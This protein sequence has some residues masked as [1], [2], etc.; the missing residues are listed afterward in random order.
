MN[1]WKQ[2]PLSSISEWPNIGVGM[3][4]LLV[5]LWGVLIGVLS[6]NYLYVDPGHFSGI[7]FTVTIVV[8]LIVLF[9]NGF[10]LGPIWPKGMVMVLLWLAF[11]FGSLLSALVNQDN[12]VGE[13]WQMWGVPIVYFFAFPRLACRKGCL[14]LAWS[15]VLGAIPYIIVSLANYPLITSYYK[16]V[17]T[18]P[19]AMGAMSAVF[20]AGGFSLLRGWISY[21]N[22]SSIAK[23]C[24]LTL[25]V[26]N[27]SVGILILFS[28]SRTSLISFFV[29]CTIFIASLLYDAEPRRRSWGKWLLAALL[30]IIG[31][32]TVFSAITQSIGL[33]EMIFSKFN[34]TP[35]ISAL[36]GREEIWK[37]IISEATLLGYGN[38]YFMD[39]IGRLPHNSYLAV[40]GTKGIMSCVTLIIFHII[41]LVLAIRYSAYRIRQ[42]G[43]AFAPLFTVVVYLVTGMTENVGGILG[44]GLHSAFLTAVGILINNFH[45][46]NQLAL[47]GSVTDNALPIGEKDR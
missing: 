32:S 29:L 21:I 5:V 2:S 4:R 15:L 35:G 43:Y 30:L 47:K 23:I 40:L 9:L 14:V 41:A 17:F 31:I 7:R 33:S 19:N 25:V 38:D 34:V 10:Q 20:V 13:I 22:L 46:E 16:G 18:G 3:S 44:D 8:A 42:N 28:S 27:F 6:L 39:H 24:Y 37:Q 45:V 36:S 1:T 12:L 11:S 26:S